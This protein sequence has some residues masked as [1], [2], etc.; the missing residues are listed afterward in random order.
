[1]LPQNSRPCTSSTSKP[2]PI[3]GSVDGGKDALKRE[4][5]D[6]EDGRHAADERIVR[7]VHLLID[8]HEAGLPVVRV[9]DRRPLL[10]AAAGTRARRG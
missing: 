9:D 4:V 2:R 7:Q 8:G 10:R 3:A 6:R 1:M 5:V